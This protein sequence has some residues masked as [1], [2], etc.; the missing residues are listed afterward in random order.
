VFTPAEAVAETV[1]WYSRRHAAGAAFDA[2]VACRDQIA[3]YRG[4]QTA[5]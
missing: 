3:A 2:R 1:A 5:A 4:R